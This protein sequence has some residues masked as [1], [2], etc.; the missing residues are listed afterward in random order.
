[1]S[2]ATWKTDDLVC[3]ES[4]FQMEALPKPSD[5]D[6]YLLGGPKGIV[7]RPAEGHV[8]NAFHRFMQRVCFGFR[9][10]KRGQE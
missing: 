1:M 8:P 7:L 5:W 2:D 9:W 6:C 3:R 4:G 10:V